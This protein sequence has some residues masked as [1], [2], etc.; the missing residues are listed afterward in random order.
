M[1]D[2]R[3]T[4]HLTDALAGIA[5]WY[6]PTADP[7][8]TLTSQTQVAYA[9]KPPLPADV[10]SL[11]AQTVDTLTT[12]AALIQ[13]ERDLHTRI[14][15][16]D[17]PALTSFLADH[18]NWL[19]GYEEGKFAARE[20]DYLARRLEEIVRQTM[21][22]RVKAI[23]PCPEHEC[24]GVL[25]AIVRREDDLL[26]SHVYCSKVRDHTWAPDEWRALRRRLAPLMDAAG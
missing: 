3:L 1:T 13:R 25:E 9:S 16:S 14:E 11:R 26:P 23:A 12:W 20:F 21:P 18:A 17:V 7:P 6:P 8:H 10:L 19:A 22:A 15:A 4:G 2:V 5:R 24:T